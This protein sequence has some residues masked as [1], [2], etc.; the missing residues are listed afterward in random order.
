[1]VPSCRRLAAERATYGSQDGLTPS[2][3]M[4]LGT[5]VFGC[6]ARS[7]SGTELRVASGAM[8]GRLPFA[9]FLCWA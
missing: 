6:R 4:S 1:M 8:A 7:Y 9:A 2:L 5:C 3:G